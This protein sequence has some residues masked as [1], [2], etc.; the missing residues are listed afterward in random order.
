MAGPIF[1]NHGFC[2][3][4]EHEVFFTAW[5]A[6]LRDTYLCGN[7]GS[8]PRER[9]LM[10]LLIELY[11]NW[12]EMRIHESSPGDRGVSPKLLNECRGYVAT[13]YRPDTPEGGYHKDGW[14]CENIEHQTFD[15]ESFDLVITQDVFEHIFDP[16]SAAREIARTLRT[17][18]A[19]IFTTPLVRGKEKTICCATKDQNGEIHH[20]Q[21]PDYHGNPVDDGGSLVTFWWGYDLASIIDDAAPMTTRIEN[22]SDRHFGIDGP[23]LEVMVSVKEQR[24]PD[25][26]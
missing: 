21:A 1:V 9:A 15:D 17:G 20:W 18:G 25:A 7:C 11:P 5:S 24:Q 14:R 22:F 12:R 16:A 26:S 19:H 13:Q 8:I 4:C 3:I 23:L 10:R 6:Q 2:P